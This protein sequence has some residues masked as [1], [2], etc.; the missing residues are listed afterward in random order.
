MAKDNY[1]TQTKLHSNQRC[2][3]CYHASECTMRRATEK[4]TSLAAKHGGIC[5]CVGTLHSHLGPSVCM[6]T[7][8]SSEMLTTRDPP[9][10]M[11]DAAG[12]A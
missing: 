5:S 1:K 9:T 2:C 4:A 7:E 3:S 8:S 6:P 11:A 10:C 12:D